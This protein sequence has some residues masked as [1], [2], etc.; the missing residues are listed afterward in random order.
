MAPVETDCKKSAVSVP[1]ETAI[2]DTVWDIDVV[3]VTSEVAI[4]ETNPSRE[5]VCADL[6]KATED[7]SYQVTAQENYPKKAVVSVIS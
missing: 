1:L 3:D 5:P 7:V 6:E 2:V 4:M